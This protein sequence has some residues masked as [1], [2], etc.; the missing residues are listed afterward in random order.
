MRLFSPEHTPAIGNV[1]T[2]K[3]HDGERMTNGIE[4]R[5]PADDE[6]PTPER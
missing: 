4:R 3:S 5:Q 6:V 1:P 2:A